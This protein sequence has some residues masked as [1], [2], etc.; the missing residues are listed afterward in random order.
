MEILKRG[1]E[2]MVGQISILTIQ[3]SNLLEMSGFE[4]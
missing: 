1:M 4:N 3:S 2:A